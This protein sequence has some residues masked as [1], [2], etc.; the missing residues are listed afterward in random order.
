MLRDLAAFNSIIDSRSDRS[1]VIDLF[2]VDP[3]AALP[4]PL[5]PGEVMGAIFF[6]L[7]MQFIRRGFP[8]DIPADCWDEARWSR[9]E[10]A[11]F[12]QHL[13]GNSLR[14]LKNYLEQVEKEDQG[15]RMWQKLRGRAARLEAR[16]AI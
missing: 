1:S 15:R 14:D 10:V 8:I 6:T 12:F 4:R 7:R 16:R 5:L 11:V 3:K 13:E 9:D 2:M